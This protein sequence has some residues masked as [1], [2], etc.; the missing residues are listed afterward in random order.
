MKRGGREGGEEEG[1][2][3]ND[4]ETREEGKG[5]VVEKKRKDRENEGEEE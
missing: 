2:I 1:G 4:Y 5:R 3:G